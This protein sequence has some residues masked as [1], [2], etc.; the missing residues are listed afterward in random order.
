MIFD[1]FY[2][3]EAE[4]FTFYRIPKVLFT[5]NYFRGLSTDAK[6]LYGLMLDRMCLSA[7][8]G[9]IDEN[10]RVYIIFTLKQVME[11]M[12]CG[13]DKGCK[14]LAELDS[15]KGIG[16]I[17]RVTRGLGKPAIIYVKSFLIKNENSEIQETESLGDLGKINRNQEFENTEVQ[18]SENPKSGLL[19]NRS[20]E[21]GKSAPNNTE[22]NN[23]NFNNINPINQDNNINNIYEPPPDT[24]KWIDRYNK[25]VAEIKE[26]V[27]YDYLINVT[28]RNIVDEVVNIMADVMTVYRPTYKIEGNVVNYEA[29]INNFRKITAEKLEICLLAFSRRNKKIHNTKSYWV[30]ALYNIPLTSN[31]ALQ[32]MVINDMQCASG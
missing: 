12:N 28:E 20:Q 19:K 32:N 4:Q 25:T 31:L 16:L 7:R 13:K 24:G 23:N 5:D 3:N 8:K 15:D 22:L 11:Y 26:Q 18:S 2:G 6:V 14:L 9:W 30:T 1:Y 17:E 21:F 27:D 29:V 10:N